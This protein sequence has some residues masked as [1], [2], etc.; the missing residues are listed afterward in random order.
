MFWTSMTT[1]TSKILHYQKC[2]SNCSNSSSVI[3]LYRTLAPKKLNRT[4]LLFI[5]S[6]YFTSS[7]TLGSHGC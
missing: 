1:E 4:T 3:E 2:T 5:H 6:I 7:N